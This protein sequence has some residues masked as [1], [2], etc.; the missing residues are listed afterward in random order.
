MIRCIWNWFDSWQVEEEEVIE[1]PCEA[2]KDLL[3]REEVLEEDISVRQL[4][5]SPKPQAPSPNTSL[6]QMVTKWQVVAVQFLPKWVSHLLSL[7]N[8][9]FFFR[10][11][12]P[13][14]A[15]PIDLFEENT[16]FSRNVV[17]T[18]YLYP[19]DRNWILNTFDQRKKNSRFVYD[20]FYTYIIFIEGHGDWRL[21]TKCYILVRFLDN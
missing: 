8:V 2:I 15:T 20:F 13:V 7:N 19:N 9:N 21:G 4:L 10:W 14:L 6:G 5:R 1:R 12:D 17:E 3:I 18:L 16:T 11:P